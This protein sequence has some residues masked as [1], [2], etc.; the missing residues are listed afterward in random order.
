MLK[1][2]VKL[3]IL[4]GTIECDFVLSDIPPIKDYYIRLNSGMNIR[5]IKDLDYD[6]L[7]YYEKSLTDSMS[8]GESSAYYFPRGN[9]RRGRYLPKKIQ[10]KYTGMYPV[11]KKDSS[12]YSVEDWKGNLAFNG[13]SL[14]ADGNQ[15]AWYPVLYDITHDRMYGELRYDVEVDCADCGNIYINGNL[16]ASGPRARLTS[17]VPYQ[18]TIFSGNYQVVN[19]GGSYFLNP[20]ISNDDVRRFAEMSNGYK[21][22]LEKKTGIPYKGNPV[23]IQTTPT[24]ERNA[25]LFVSYPSIF[26][27]GRGEFGMSK[28]LNKARSDWS[29]S[30]IAH[31]LGHYYF[32]TYRDFNS[33]LGD[34]INEGFAEYLSYKTVKAL[35]SDSAYQ[36]KLNTK[37]SAI[38]DFKPVPFGKVA[39]KDDYNNRELYVYYYAPIIF[40]AI[41][42]EIG[43]EKMWKWIK[44]LLTTPAV[45]TDYGFLKQCLFAA[46]NDRQLTEQLSAQYFTSDQSTKNALDKLGL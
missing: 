42:K 35:I 15:S 46:L 6:N 37:A 14:R 4:Q 32:G 28:F 22:Y 30:Y 5:Y 39:A 41:E 29:R 45:I 3:S 23:Y 9:D 26:N 10:F 33:L 44:Q 19:I 8:T 20:D 1:G 18:L 21:N 40:L 7:L 13:Y 36:I 12:E 24:S 2:K 25:W 38:R 43:E 34:M 27:I 17:N 16:P 31:E 11:F